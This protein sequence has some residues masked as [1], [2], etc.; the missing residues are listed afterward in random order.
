MWAA[1][2]VI[3]GHDRDSLW[4]DGLEAATATWSPREDMR[5]PLGEYVREAWHVVEPAT[6]YVHGWHIDAIVDHLAA[7]SRGEIRNL[8][9]NMPPRFAKS[10]LV[11][12]F[13]PT[14]SWTEDPAA[15]WLYASYV[16]T[17]STRDALK[18]RRIIQSPWYQ[19]RWG[20][21]FRLTGDQNAKMRYENDRTGY[22]IATAV[23]GL[24]TGD[25]GDI[26][27]VDDPHNAQEAQS[28]AVRESAL[29]WWDETMSTRLN[30]SKTGRRVIV[31]QRLHERDLSGHVLEQGGYEHLCLPME[32]EPKPQVPGARFADPR[33]EPGELLWPERVGP[34]ELA[35]L[36]L[37]LGSYAASGQLQQRPSPA[38]GGIFKRHWWRFWQPKGVDLPP[39]PVKLPDGTTVLQHPVVRPDVMQECQSWDMAFKDDAENDFVCGQAWGKQS[40]NAYLLDQDL[41]RRDFPATVAAVINFTARHPRT[42]A[43]YVE[44]KANGSA[45]IATLRNKIPGL[46]AV[47]PEGGKIA[48]AHAAAP[49]IEAGNVY[50]PHPAIAPWVWAF[51][52]SCAAF[53]NAA[54]DDDVDSMTQA[55]KRLLATPARSGNFRTSTASVSI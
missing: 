51:I 5:L 23:G 4:D 54:H 31:M 36:K 13:W 49:F 47:N 32:Y 42:N 30:D 46:I 53:P 2:P 50:L 43:K 28:D 24:A 27:V 52:E 33:T 15:R 16:Q 22:R 14:W 7:V 29:T 34:P 37:R 3:S 12:V 45:V 8:L 10:L 11:S 18:S 44:D 25:G 6:P 38:E 41:Q 19:S 1:H 48:R 55:L 26:I 21:R 40:A 9:I 17:L 35:D 20:H 39:V